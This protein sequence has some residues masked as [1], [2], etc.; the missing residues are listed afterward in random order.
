MGKA[1]TNTSKMQETVDTL[2][3]RTAEL[4]IGLAQWAIKLEAISKILINKEVYDIKTLQK[5]SEAMV[6][7]MYNMPEEVNVKVTTDGEVV[8]DVDCDAEPVYADCYPISSEK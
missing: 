1:I 6:R 2:Y 5:E 3:K 7:E 8:S 4:E